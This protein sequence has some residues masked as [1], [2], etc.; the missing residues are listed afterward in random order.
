MIVSILKWLGLFVLFFI[1]QTT[2]VPIISIG[3][4]KPD[5]LILGLFLLAIRTGVMPGL[6]VGFL[7]GLGKDLY[8]PSILGQNALSNTIMGFFV[9]LFNERFMRTDPIL[10]IVI[11]LLGIILHDTIF[12]IVL[13]VKTEA[14]MSMLAPELI[15]RSLPRALYTAFFAALIYLWDYF[16]KPSM[17]Y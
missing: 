12:T 5:L 16:I 3:G 7:L 17:K 4:V 2:F 6:Y 8:S 13:I 14:D 10:K 9:G 1:L 11:L 15:T